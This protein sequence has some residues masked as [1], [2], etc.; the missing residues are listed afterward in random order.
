MEKP[1]G[2]S[3]TD[4]CII[5]GVLCILSCILFPRVIG[6]ARGSKGD[7]FTTTVI[8][9]K[10]PSKGHDGRVNLI[11]YNDSADPINSVVVQYASLGPMAVDRYSCR[12]TKVRYELL[13][14]ATSFEAKFH[15]LP[16]NSW[17]CVTVDYR[18]VPIGDPYSPPTRPGW[19]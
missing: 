11:A 7:P 9:V 5:C 2:L 13:T 4:F 16:P 6:P 1:R 17:T 19:R 8:V 3:L 15:S 12:N 10:S 18:P 14:S